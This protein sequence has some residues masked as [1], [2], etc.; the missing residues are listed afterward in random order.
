MGVPQSVTDLVLDEV[1][2][3]V[4]DIALVLGYAEDPSPDIEHCPAA[5]PA[6]DLSMRR[7]WS[8]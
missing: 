5:V 1:A 4:D 7:K 8:T 3:I 6:T 2:A